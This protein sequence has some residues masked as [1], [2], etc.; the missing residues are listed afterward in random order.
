MNGQ[1]KIIGAICAAPALALAP[2]GV[3]E[4]KRAT[5]YPGF[6]SNFSSS[7]QFSSDRVVVDEHVITSCGPGSALEFA[8]ELVEKLAGPEKAEALSES[9]LVR[10]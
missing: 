8:I 10:S 4:G 3:L 1:K 2:S 9:L 6:E 5:C 7:V